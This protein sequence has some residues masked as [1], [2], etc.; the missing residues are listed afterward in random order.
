MYSMEPGWTDKVSMTSGG[1]VHQ[2]QARC[3]ESLKKTT[4]HRKTVQ[5]DGAVLNFLDSFCCGVAGLNTCSPVCGVPQYVAFFYF[6]M[7]TSVNRYCT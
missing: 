7:P 6:G 2:V 3:F 1:G 4:W 5:L